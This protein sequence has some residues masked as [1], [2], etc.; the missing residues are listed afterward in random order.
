VDKLYDRRGKNG[1]DC[2]G[3]TSEQGV[4]SEDRKTHWV[5]IW[6]GILFLVNRVAC[7]F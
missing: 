7:D 1:S 2:I 3:E 6:T 4:F 5:S